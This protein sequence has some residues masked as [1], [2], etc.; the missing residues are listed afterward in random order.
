VPTTASPAASRST[1]SRGALAFALAVV[2]IAQA[3]FGSY[4]GVAVAAG[5]QVCSASG[6][7]LV[8]DAD[9]DLLPAAG[10]HLG[11]DCCC[12]ALGGPSPSPVTWQPMLLPRQV[13]AANPTQREL[14]AQWLAPLSRGPP[15][16]S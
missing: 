12:T 15:S 9:G 11:H 14:A 1:P 4:L 13:R 6:A 16:L 8:V 10:A 2:L 5:T 3:L 7:A